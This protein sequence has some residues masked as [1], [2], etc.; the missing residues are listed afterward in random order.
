MLA[1]TCE[2]VPPRRAFWVLVLACDLILL[3]ALPRILHVAIGVAALAAIGVAYRRPEW[4]IAFLILGLP[5]LAPLRVGATASTL[6]MV[7]LPLIALAGWTRSGRDHSAHASRAIRAPSTLCLLLFTA[8]IFSGLFWTSAV[9]YGT[10]KAVG[11]VLRGLIPFLVAMLMGPVWSERRGMDRFLRAA[12]FLGALVAGVGVLAALGWAGPAL[13][14]NVGPRGGIAA[15]RLAW[16]GT[17]AI[18]LARL[19]AVWFVVLLWAAQRRLI[20][21]AIAGGGGALAL[22]LILLSG[23]R[24]PLAALLLSPVSLLMVPRSRPVARSGARPAL[25]AAGIAAL[26]LLALLPGAQK[27]RMASAVLRVPAAGGLSEMATDQLLRDPSSMFRT[28]LARRSLGILADGLPWGV[29]TGGFSTAA[30]RRDVR[31]YPHNLEAEILFENG[32]PGFLLLVAFLILIWRNARRLIRAWPEGRWLWLLFAMALLNAQVSGDLPMNVGV[33]FWGG[34]IAAVARS[35]EGPRGH[36]QRIE[37]T[38]L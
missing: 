20:H 1:A 27:Q 23:S 7:G 9:G 4:T 34:M 8:W 37:I 26:V 10:D 29:G 11:F 14:G 15:P 13:L 6:I 12:L 25:V 21:P 36:P 16:L 28:Q 5:L 18:W 2:P 17:N 30:F 22:V 3:F 32:L 24:G 35:G 19:L 33:W 31:V 38:S